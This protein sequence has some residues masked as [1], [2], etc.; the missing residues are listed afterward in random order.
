MVS[1]GISLLKRAIASSRVQPLNIRNTRSVAAAGRMG[2]LPPNGR[3]ST[4]GLALTLPQRKRGR[5]DDERGIRRCAWI[6][7][8]AAGPPMSTPGA[9]LLLKLHDME[10]SIKLAGTSKNSSRQVAANLTR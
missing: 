3:G 10:D 1:A 8:F 5:R 2:R 6:G 7:P 4:F 9:P